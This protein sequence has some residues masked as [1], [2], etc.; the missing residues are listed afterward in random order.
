[1][2]RVADRLLGSNALMSAT[3]RSETIAQVNRSATTAPATRVG[4]AIYL[5]SGSPE[6]AVLR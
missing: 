3:L 6:F 2:N 5:I 4:D 1:M